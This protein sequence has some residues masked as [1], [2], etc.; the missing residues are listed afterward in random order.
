MPY[1]TKEDKKVYH[2]KWYQEHK[3]RVLE[4]N[5]KNKAKHRKKFRDFKATLICERCGESHH[6]T[7]DFHHKD[8]NQKENTVNRMYSLGFSMDNLKKEIAK[9][10]VLCAN[11]H[12]KE[13]AK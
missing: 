8:P 7:L 12:R 2:Q 5:A 1:K 3:P 4:L 10:E 11:C 9:C 13:H 6:A